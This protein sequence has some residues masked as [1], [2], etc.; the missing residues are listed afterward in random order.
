MSESTG[1]ARACVHFLPLRPFPVFFCNSRDERRLAGW[2]VKQSFVI[3]A[4]VCTATMT[5]AWLIGNRSMAKKTLI[6]VVCSKSIKLAA[7]RINF[8]HLSLVNVPASARKILYH[9]KS[10]VVCRR[11][12]SE[13]KLSLSRVAMAMKSPKLVLAGVLVR[14]DF[15]NNFPVEPQ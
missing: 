11:E 9:N 8:L 1:N 15:P 7:L 14:K 6:K 2:H 4:D 3:P 5:A 12:A 13:R 10:D